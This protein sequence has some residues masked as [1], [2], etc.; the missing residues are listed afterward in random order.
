MMKTD[1]EIQGGVMQMLNRFSSFSFFS[2]LRGFISK[3]FSLTQ[4]FG[5]LKMSPYKN[6][7]VQ[8]GDMN[9][10]TPIS[11]LLS[12]VIWSALLSAP[13]YGAAREKFH[14]VYLVSVDDLKSG[15]N[16]YVDPIFFTNG[17]E[18]K[19]F[20]DFC[21]S[22]NKP[23][24]PKQV[25]ASDQK[26]ID[27]YC[28]HKTF[29]FDPKDY[30]TLNNHGQQVTL[31]PIEFRVIDHIVQTKEAVMLGHSSVASYTTGTIN[32]PKWLRGDGAPEYFFLMIKDKTILEKIMPV[33][34]ATK[35]EI[36][37]L[38]K[39]AEEFSKLAK[40]KVTGSPVHIKNI[41]KARDCMH[42]KSIV[43][44]RIENPLIGDLDFD[45]K[46][47]MLVGAYAVVRLD[48][49]PDKP[50]VDCFTRYQ[51]LGNGD[52]Y[53]T[54]NESWVRTPWA[55]RRHPGGVY[56]RYL[57]NGYAPHA[58]LMVINLASENRLC[59]YGAAYLAQSHLWHADGVVLWTNDRSCPSIQLG[60]KFR[61]IFFEP[62]DEERE[63]WSESKQPLR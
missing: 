52:T 3:R 38:V 6:H 50:L 63:K 43:Q 37:V 60:S 26:F 35:A 39:R 42:S 56:E 28:A 12:I 16:V 30:Y 24:K 22:T 8:G 59:A 20:H 54:G 40:G 11:F 17:K 7:D 5:R 61:S 45:G 25:A 57:N 10:K 44:F 9:F 34:R 13:A 18:V 62:G 33:S 55:S 58:P 48:G 2:V 49:E 51:L 23:L 47:D 21:R 31:E 53:L 1:N 14:L 36:Q 15:S 4:L 41:E 46:I 27:N 19:N 29:T 32:P